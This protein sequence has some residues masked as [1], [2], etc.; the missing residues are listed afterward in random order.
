M[1]MAFHVWTHGQY[2]FSL[3]SSYPD[4]KIVINLI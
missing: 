4:S 1:K 3:L 2:G